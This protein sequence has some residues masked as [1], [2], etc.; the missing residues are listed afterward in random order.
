LPKGTGIPDL[1][2]ALS[3]SPSVRSSDP[4]S[5]IRV[6][7]IGAQSVSTDR[8]PTAAAM[9]SMGWLL[10]GQQIVAVTTFI[11]DRWGNRAPSV[12]EED[13]TKERS[14]LPQHTQ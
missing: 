2:P 8:A 7:L 9:P 13:V 5:L 14:A 6:I 3:N 4:T 1:F 10:T 11:R 12:I